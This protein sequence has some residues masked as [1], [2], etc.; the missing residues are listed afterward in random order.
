M[1][2]REIHPPRDR[3]IAERA[4]AALDEIQS[5]QAHRPDECAGKQARFQVTKQ[6][7]ELVEHADSRATGIDEGRHTL[8]NADCVG[9]GEAKRAIGMNVNV[10]PA[11]A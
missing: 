6:F 11:G 7:Y 2:L 3:D 9:I 1:L 8:I 4:N 5:E 10:D